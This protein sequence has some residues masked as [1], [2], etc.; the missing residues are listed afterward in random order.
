MEPISKPTRDYRAIYEMSLL[1]GWAVI[2]CQLERDR[3]FYQKLILNPKPDTKPP[4]WMSD[5]HQ[6][7]IAKG[8]QY[9]AGRILKI[10]EDARE[11]IK[12]GDGQ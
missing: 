5:L 11:K 9:E 10:V 1:P 3:D 6:Q 7:G 12:Q 2:Q 4:E 8:M